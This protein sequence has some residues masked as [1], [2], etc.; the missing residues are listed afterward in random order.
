MAP[1]GGNIPLSL[2]LCGFITKVSINLL[3]TIGNVTS[4]ETQMICF[5]ILLND[6]NSILN[7][8]IG[9]CLGMWN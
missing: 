2:R 8:G 9:R 1:L 4:L 5:E 7:V 6:L 3:R